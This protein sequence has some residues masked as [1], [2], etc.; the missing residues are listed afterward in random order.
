MNCQEP[1]NQWRQA[2]SAQPSDCIHPAG[3]RTPRSDWN[4]I[5]Q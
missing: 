1:H 2:A 5:E 3:G 4:Y